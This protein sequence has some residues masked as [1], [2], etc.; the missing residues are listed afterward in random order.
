MATYSWLT[1]TAAISALQGRLGAGGASWVPSLEAQGY[2]TQ[3]LREWNSLTEQWNQEF[4]FPSVESQTW[5]N[6]GTLSGSPRLRTVTDV[7]LYTMMQNMLL[8]PPVGGAWAGTNQFQLSDLQN[9]LSQRRN[10]VIQASGCNIAQLSP[11]GTTP[12]ALRT[13]LGDTVLEPRRIRFVPAAGSPLTLTREDT[14]A[15]QFFVPGYLGSQPSTGPKSWSVASEPPL[16]FD[17]DRAPNV[18]GAYD[19]IALVSGPPL[20]PP[21]GTLLGVPDD[22]SPLPMWGALADVL[23]QEPEKTDSYRAAYCLKRYTDGL[24]VLRQSNWLV[25]ANVNGVPCDTPSMYEQDW[26]SPEWSNNANAWPVVVQAGMDLVGVY[27]SGGQSVG[28]TLVGNAPI[29][30]ATNT[31]VQIARDQWDVVLNY[32]QRLASFKGGEFQSTESLEKDFYRAAR[33]VNK[34][35]LDMGI[36]T[37]MLHTEGERQDENVPRGSDRADE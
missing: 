6:T 14:Q 26:T 12:G 32:A 33:Q 9:A 8:E 15:F 7:S 25:Q 10:E 29:L 20:A 13:I 24:D 37:E 35:L 28:V 19:V 27:P 18:A 5:Y 23:S 30:D 11:L 22:W 1:L 2:I 3:A 36:F 17:V 4:V 21:A 31:Y 16:A 34:R